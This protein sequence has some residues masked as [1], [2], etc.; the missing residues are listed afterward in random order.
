MKKALAVAGIICGIVAIILGCTILNA[1]CGIWQDTT[2]SFGADFYTYSYK[3]TARAANNV[4]DMAN[5]LRSGFAY[6]LMTLGTFE[7]LYFGNLAIKAFEALEAENTTS[8]ESSI[9]ETRE[10]ENTPVFESPVLEK[11]QEETNADEMEEPE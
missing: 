8:P 6:L 3:A 9:F 5:I 2:V 1:D 4:M 7:A 10:S 11:A